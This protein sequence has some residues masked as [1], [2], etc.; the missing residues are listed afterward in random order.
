MQDY[1]KAVVRE[2]EGGKI[3]YYDNL[4]IANKP[5]E[6]VGSRRVREW[7]P[8][9][10]LKRTWMETLDKSGSVRQVRPE[11]GGTKTH[12]M[13]DRKGNYVQKW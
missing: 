12:Y 2:L 3:R 8:K 9:N 1:G 5:G 10:D 4:K 6:M 11:T 7:D 13:F